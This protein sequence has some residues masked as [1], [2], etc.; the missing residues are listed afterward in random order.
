MIL[1][2]EIYENLINYYLASLRCLARQEPAFVEGKKEKQFNL[3]MPLKDRLWENF[4][5]INMH[6]TDRILQVC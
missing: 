3:D 6:D 4:K 1:N 2:I 5:W